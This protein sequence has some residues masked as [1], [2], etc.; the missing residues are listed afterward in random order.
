MC[1]CVEPQCCRCWVP[2]GVPGQLWVCACA[3]VGCQCGGGPAAAAAAKKPAHR[4][5]RTEQQDDGVLEPFVQDGKEAFWGYCCECV[6]AIRVP[7]G[8]HC[9]LGQP[10]LPAAPQGSC[11]AVRP[12]ILLIQSLL[13]L[14][15]QQRERSRNRGGFDQT[16]SGRPAG[17]CRTFTNRQHT[18]LRA[19]SACGSTVDG[20][21]V[22]IITPGCAARM[23]AADETR[24]GK[25]SGVLISCGQRALSRL[26]G[27]ALLGTA[28]CGL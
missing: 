15:L 21:E 7:G 16:L 3:S 5:G 18:V 20:I 9:P 24:C 10:G 23:C 12:T 6:C 17:H 14:V 8:L 1:V 27:P 26:C 4:S 22:A 19:R 25:W 11:Q 13:V 2:R 28:A